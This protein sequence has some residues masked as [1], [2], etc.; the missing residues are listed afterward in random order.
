MI[1]PP[2]PS[3]PLELVRGTVREGTADTGIPPR[4]GCPLSP[5]VLPRAT[6]REVQRAGLA[7]LD[8]SRR[9]VLDLGDSTQARMEAF[10]TTAEDYPLFSRDQQFEDRFCD[11]FAR[12]DFVVTD[13][14]PQILEFNVSGAVG[15][16]P[17]LSTLQSA[18][19]DVYARD[20]G[21]TWD[22][23]D[24]YDDRART[25]A[26]VVRA[27]G[28]E[29]RV[30]VLGSVRDL[31]HT[32]STKIFD[33]E[34][35]ALDR[36]GLQGDFAEPEG[37]VPLLESLPAG[38]VSHPLSL[39]M[40]TVPEW[41]ELGID[42]TPVREWLDR[43][44]WLLT[45]QTSSFLANKKTLAWLS[46]GL[47]WMTARERE[48]V[49]RYVP[50][51][52]VTGDR[53]TS[54]PDGSRG[55]LGTYALAHQDDLVLKKGIGMQGLQVT[56]GRDTTAAG[57]S[58]AVEAA[59]RDTDSVVQRYVEPSLQEVWMSHGPAEDEVELLRTRPIV[60]YF[61]FGRRAGSGWAR[62]RPDDTFGVVSRE[63]FNAYETA[64]APR[65]ETP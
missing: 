63:G 10:G 50:W 61:L 54:L 17:E 65:E 32:D 14:G 6:E 18:L 62:F 20:E 64:I 21:V 51:S 31:K 2:R 29:P 39:R 35:A 48:L 15:G 55:A 25:F 30:L 22:W 52:R 44:S 58:D 47:P 38:A 56:V 34:V 46:E 53:D 16:V 8:L 59:V 27:C 1:T 36:A 60:S 9:T 11:V 19:S 33:L 7:L 23:S 4:E 24:P 37:L 12:P 26:D 45:S 49:D 40:F 3:A 28:L 43:G 5:V 13:A 41:A 57:W 42:L